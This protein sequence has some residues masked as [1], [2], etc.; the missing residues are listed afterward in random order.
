LYAVSAG[1]V[2]TIARADVCYYEFVGNCFAL[3]QF[4]ECMCV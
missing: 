3:A 4:R 2:V 1:L